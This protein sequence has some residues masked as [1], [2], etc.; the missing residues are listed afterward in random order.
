MSLQKI[1]VDKHRDVII[2]FRRD[3]FKVSF[4]TDH[5][6]KRY[7]KERS[8]LGNPRNRMA[9]PNSFSPI[10]FFNLIQHFNLGTFCFSRC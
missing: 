3:S 8:S 9:I 7:K 4:G 5:N 1:D 10:P 6:R 2:S